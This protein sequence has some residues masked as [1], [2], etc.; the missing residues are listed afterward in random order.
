MIKDDVIKN[1]NRIQKLSKDAKESI[2]EI[3]KIA[4]DDLYNLDKQTKQIIK[5]LKLEYN[6]T[7]LL[8]S[9][10][11]V[12]HETIMSVVRDYFKVDFTKKTRKSEYKEPRQ[13]A[14]YLFRKYT[15]LS[16]GDIA[17]YVGLGDHTTVI[18]AIKKVEDMMYTDSSYKD[19]I[20]ELESILK[21]TIKTKN[22]NNI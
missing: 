5:D 19:I 22:D 13:M 14:C 10:Q 7:K 6:S 12:N 21:A 1:I 18:H 15:G 11:R 4:M 17:I 16:L 3:K 2:N 20:L 9:K 8:V